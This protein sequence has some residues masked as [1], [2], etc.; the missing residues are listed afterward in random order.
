MVSCHALQQL[1]NFS[2]SVLESYRPRFCLGNSGPEDDTDNS[3]TLS[4]RL[5][6]WMESTLA[7][8]NQG[9]R[10]A[11]N[12]LVV[13][14]CN[15]PSSGVIS[16]SKH[17]FVLSQVTSLAN[18]FPRAFVGVIVMPNRASDLRTGSKRLPQGMFVAAWHR[19]KPSRGKRRRMAITT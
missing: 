16:A 1:L 13:A 17:H 7:G 15:Y 2:M 8:L 6:P 14:L 3:S 19:G 11:D 18:T 4:A 9:M 12:E 10:R 5:L